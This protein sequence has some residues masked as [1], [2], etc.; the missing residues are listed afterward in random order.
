MRQNAIREFKLWLVFMLAG[1]AVLAAELSVKSRRPAIPDTISY[2]HST[3]FDKSIH[4]SEVYFEALPEALVTSLLVESVV[5][6]ES[7]G[8]PE[9]VGG[10][11]ERGLMQIKEGTWRD[12]TK[13]LYG[14]SISFDRAF[15]PELNRQ[16]GTAY[17]AYLHDFIQSHRDEW[18][19]DERA[20][21]LACY[22]AGPRRVANAKFD[23][24][25]LPAST[26]DYVQRAQALH[27][28]YL[29]DHAI[30]LAPGRGRGGMQIVQTLPSQGT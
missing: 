19:A 2:A 7:G 8:R 4:S 10:K 16:V 21:L 29:N 5:Q 12:T 13:R 15:D 27:D 17:L 3:S 24:S 14:R 25:K 20:L 30:K 28:W 11:G 1:S 9:I 18:Q 26:R 6:I 22:N 23:I